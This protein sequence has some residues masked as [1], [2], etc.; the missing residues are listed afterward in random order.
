LIAFSLSLL[1][2]FLV[3]SG[4]LTSVHSFASDP[5]RGLYIL[6]FLMLVIGGSLTL[7]A[8]RGPSIRSKGHFE[9]ISKEMLLLVNNVI[10]LVAAASVLLGTLYPLAI[11]A[12]KIG[13]ISVGPPYF[14]AVF[15]PLM[16]P[17]FLLI[18]FGP[19][20]RWK[21]QEGKE[22]LKPF[23]LTAIAS[24]IGGIAVLLVT[25]GELK[26]G[27][28]AGVT[29]ALWLII[30]NLQ[31][32]WNQLNRHQ[33]FWSRLRTTPLS[34]YG[35][36]ASHVGVGIVVLGITITSNYSIERDLRMD[37]GQ[38]VSLA[39]YDFRFDGTIA[40]PGPN[41]TANEGQILVSR[42]G[43]EVALLHPQ[44]RTYLVQRN[45]MT[46]AAIDAG[47]LRH[48]YVALGEPI[49]DTGSW[50]V[51]LYYKPLVSWIWFGPALMA[52]GGLLATLDRRYR[53]ARRRQTSAAVDSATERA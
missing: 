1:G 51:R 5:T 4:V 16:L 37:P 39:G 43:Q 45:G 9:L 29:V 32:L 34:T 36:I 13:K 21:K 19:F 11:E 6:V 17:L 47:F 42:N 53:T 30:G 7:Y 50:A 38:T 15:V 10:L 49:G 27:V 33:A 8:W 26:P 44:K 24:I 46:E 40:K 18:P 12:L 14:N 52:L 23:R 22:L 31:Y 20:A 2:T 35:M 28:L 41:Y 48:L 25:V 3:R